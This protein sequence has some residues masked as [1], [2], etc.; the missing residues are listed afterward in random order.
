MHETLMSPDL[1][2]VFNFNFP[3]RMNVTCCCL[4]LL[5]PVQG[6]QRMKVEENFNSNG[7]NENSAELFNELNN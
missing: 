3:K 7:A 2:S 1:K 5:T 6:L 4:F